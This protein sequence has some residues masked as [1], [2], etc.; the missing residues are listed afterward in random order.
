MNKNKRQLIVKYADFL[1]KIRNFFY[2]KNI[3][4]VQT[5]IAQNYGS[6]DPY[7]E[8]LS[9]EFQGTKYL[10]TSPEFAM[11]IILSDLKK[12]I[13]QI[14]K[15]F[16]ADQ[17]SQFHNFEFTMLE[18][19]RVDFCE[20]LLM[21]EI[22]ELLTK[23]FSFSKAKKIS[24]QNAFLEYLDLDPFA[25]SFLE[26]KNQKQYFKNFVGN[27]FDKDE[28]LNY[29]FAIYIEPNIAKNNPV[30][31]YDFPATQASLAKISS[32]NP[33][34]ARR[35][36]LYYKGVELANGFNELLDPNEQLQRFVL[37]N[38]KRKKLNKQELKIDPNFI[39]A[40][41]KG[42]PNS[43]GVAIGLD[44]LFML[45]ADLKSIQELNFYS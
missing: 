13:Y 26:L 35:F 11:K 34:M 28:L 36:E 32:K 41:K 37:D 10:Q 25:L 1:H 31:V 22:D 20:F 44:R 23:L 12:S 27:F 4:E 7:L 8:N 9:F 24:Y 30:F 38:Q 18:Y 39:N 15:A 42:L 29:L 17:S 16:R 6:L 3:L 2:A 19:Y 40:L 43:S 45:V 14:T 33:K 5:P 21:D